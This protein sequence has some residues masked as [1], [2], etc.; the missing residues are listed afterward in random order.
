[1][2]TLLF[3]VS[4]SQLPESMTKFIDVRATAWY[5]PSV[6][7]AHENGITSGTSDT[8][9]SPDLE[10]SRQ[11]FAVMI[12]R[13]MDKKDISMDSIREAKT[14]NDQADIDGYAKDAI[15]YLYQVGIIDGMDDG[16][17]A[18]KNNV[19]R[20]QAAKMIAVMM[21]LQE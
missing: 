1:M 13:L 8:A 5:A 6:A 21:M 4:G 20:A 18:P 17:F 11:D 12:K 14:F 16:T 19:T 10:I 2:V 15:T 3:N 9:F 7:W